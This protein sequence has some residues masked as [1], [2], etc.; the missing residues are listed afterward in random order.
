MKAF[1]L[2][3]SCLFALATTARAQ[4]LRCNVQINSDQVQ[5]QE[6]QIFEDMQQAI[7]R[8]MNTTKWT[9]EEF[10]EHEKIKCDVLITLD[11][12]NSITNFSARVQI[13]SMRPIYGTSYETPVLTFFDNNWNF[14]YTVGQPLI[15]SENTYSTELTSLLAFYA[16]AIIALDFDTFSSKGGSPYYERMLNIVN[17]SQ[18]NGGRGWASIGGDTRD[19]Y[20]LSE[21][22][23]SPQFEPFRLGLYTYHRKAMDYMADNADLARE[24]V[25]QVLLQVKAV[26]DVQP[27]AVTINA[28][29]DAKA[30]ELAQLFSQGDEAVRQEAVALLLELDPTN[31]TLYRKALK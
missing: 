17:N 31:S 25:L 16:Y 8:F 11:K 13:K 19:R 20:W 24:Q 28:F 1:L 18:G 12:G 27:T 26:R 4:E 23:N 15:F 22:L 9:D 5:T 7:Q 6:K 21:N 3:I 14:A 29:F 30:Q 10:E 2:A